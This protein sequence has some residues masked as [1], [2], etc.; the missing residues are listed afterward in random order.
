MIQ[1]ILWGKP[2]DSQR[3][4]MYNM[5]TSSNYFQEVFKYWSI[6]DDWKLVNIV[7][8][9]KKGERKMLGNCWSISLT[10]VVVKLYESLIIS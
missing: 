5:Y 6:P 10:S 9:F 7:P 1:W 3:N 8:I 2:M 4:C